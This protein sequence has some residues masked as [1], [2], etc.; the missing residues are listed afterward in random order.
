MSRLLYWLFAVLLVAVIVHISLVIFLPR[1]EMAARIESASAVKGINALTVADKDAASI[2]GYSAGES[3]YAFCPFDLKNGDL[4]LDALMPATL[5][6]LTIYSA[7][8]TNVYSVN[9]RQ[10]GVDNFQISV[11]KA[12]DFLT[13][14]TAD[15]DKGAINDGWQVETNEDRGLIVLWAAVSESFQRGAIEKDMARSSCHS[16]AK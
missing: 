9:N 6:A 2:L 12:P 8:G 16:V 4:V 1:R 15:V 7:R 14:V 5:W 13:Q 11:R 10:A 3:V